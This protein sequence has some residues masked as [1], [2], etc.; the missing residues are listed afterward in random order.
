MKLFKGFDDLKAGF[1]MIRRPGLRRYVVMP[2][3]LNILFFGALGV[4]A[5]SGFNE[6]VNWVNGWLSESFAFLQYLLWLVFGLLGLFVL[7]YTFVFFATLIGAPFYGLLADK[8]LE[9]MGAKTA[10]ETL[11]PARF[12]A[13]I[14][15]IMWREL[16]KILQYLPGVI[17]LVILSFIPV[18]NLIV[19]VLWVLFSAW[20]TALEFLDFPADAQGQSLRDL[21][22]MMR[23]DRQRCFGFG[24]MAWA[25][26]LVP[27][28]NLV[29]MQAAVAGGV[30]LWLD[31]EGEQRSRLGKLTESASL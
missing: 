19:P 3:C 29:V 13:M 28:V 17:L 30:R 15:R 26:T 7:A 24:L 27:I 20:K 4:W 25:L 21:K 6:W 31:I 1:A 16:Q 14:P 2:L 23:E 18:I 22:R 9:E 8:V 5:A 10:E 12:L 11:T